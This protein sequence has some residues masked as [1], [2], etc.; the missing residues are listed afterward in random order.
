MPYFSR[1][2]P[3]L[4]CATIDPVHSFN[5]QMH[6]QPT[7]CAASKGQH[8]PVERRR[9]ETLASSADSP[10]CGTQLLP[11]TAMASL[12]RSLD[13]SPKISFDPFIWAWEPLSVYCALGPAL[14]SN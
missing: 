8:S 2:D 12:V 11:A 13:G 5:G 7:K 3:M 14:L 6:A 10:A 9:S 4:C 1:L